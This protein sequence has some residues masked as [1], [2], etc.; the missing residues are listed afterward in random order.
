MLITPTRYVQRPPEVEAL[1]ITADAVD[2]ACEWLRSYGRDA[3]A[4]TAALRVVEGPHGELGFEVPFGWYLLRGT[5]FA[6]MAPLEFEA[7]F[8]SLAKSRGQHSWKDEL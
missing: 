1:L 2:A 6:P 8:E 4:E 7:R 5:Q 3:Y